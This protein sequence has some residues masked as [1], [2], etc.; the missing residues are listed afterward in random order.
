[1]LLPQ[2]RPQ[3]VLRLPPALLFVVIISIISKQALI[4]PSGG[5]S[6]APTAQKENPWKEPMRLRETGLSRLSVLPTQD[7]WEG[8]SGVGSRSQVEARARGEHL[9]AG[10]GTSSASA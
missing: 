6:Q 7:F 4:R 9:W 5:R 2:G 3:L 1:M 10:F 8:P